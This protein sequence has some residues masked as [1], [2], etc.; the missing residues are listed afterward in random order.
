MSYWSNTGK[1]QKE[2]FNFYDE[3][4]PS[5]GKAELLGGEILRAVS[6]IS[7]DYY[8][9]GSCNNTSGAWN[10]L[11]EFFMCRVPDKDMIE[12]LNCLDSIK[13]IV[14]TGGYSDLTDN[15]EEKLNRLTDLV[16][17]FIMNHPEARY[18]NDRDMFDLQDADDWI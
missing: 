4:V 1:Y 5:R 15:Q 18:C 3:L 11:N 13:H 10:F 7:Y 17:E 8:N 2:Y 12:A 9:N 6:K 16:V 14:N